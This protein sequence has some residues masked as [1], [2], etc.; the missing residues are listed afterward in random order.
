MG[1]FVGGLGLA[2]GRT[3]SKSAPGSKASR[4]YLHDLSC[5]HNRASWLQN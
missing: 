5:I 3:S 2:G 1:V 4:L